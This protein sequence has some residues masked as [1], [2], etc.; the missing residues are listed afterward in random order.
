MERV[1]LQAQPLRVPS[2]QL[3][4]LEA[5]DEFV[6]V[7]VWKK[8]ILYDGEVGKE[9][10]LKHHSMIYIVKT[11]NY[12][13]LQTPPLTSTMIRTSRGGDLWDLDNL[14]DLESAS[15]FS[16]PQDFAS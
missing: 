13:L 2:P 8:G 6:T 5:L 3:C 7:M 14:Y 4:D 1:R 12:Q 16:E 15:Y 9:R 11:S 10:K